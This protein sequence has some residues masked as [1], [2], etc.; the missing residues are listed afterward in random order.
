LR[1]GADEAKDQSYVL[2]ML[3]QR[4]LADILLPVGD[5]TKREVRAV[6]RRLGLRTAE[7]PESMDVCFVA[8]ADRAAFVDARRA[9][10]PGVVVDT[11]GTVRARHDGIANFTIGQRRGLGV[12]ADSARYVVG[13][14]ADTATVTI[15]SRAETL[16]DHIPVCDLHFV[17][18]PPRGHTVWVQTRAHGATTSGR[19]VGTSV[20]L[21]AA[22]PRVAPG[23]VVALYDDDDVV[24]GGALAA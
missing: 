11:T 7:K 24:L 12:T 13:I 9:P 21:G 3:G 8:R 6:A 18:E 14:D 5:L 16:S 15:G 2:Y 1:R 23:Q 22:I 20:L 10:R 19:L 4:D 17:H